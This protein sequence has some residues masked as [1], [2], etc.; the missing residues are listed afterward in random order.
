MTYRFNDY[1]G[2]TA[3][4]SS[5]GT[6]GHPIATGDDIGWARGNR[7]RG[8]KSETQCADCWAKW[9]D[10]NAEAD[11]LEAQSPFYGEMPEPFGPF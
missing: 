1:Q 9:V 7:R 6:C 10:E 4:F 8:R 5:T 2:I 3:K 11:R